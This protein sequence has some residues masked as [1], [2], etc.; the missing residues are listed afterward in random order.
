[1]LVAIIL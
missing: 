1:M